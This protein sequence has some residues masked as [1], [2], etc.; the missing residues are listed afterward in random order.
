MG[1]SSL[2]PI[3][4]LF[5]FSFLSIITVSFSSGSLTGSGGTA[6]SIFSSNFFFFFSNCSFSFF[7]N[8]SFA[9]KISSNCFLSTSLVLGFLFFAI[10][11]FV[12]FIS[13][14]SFFSFLTLTSFFS[15]TSSFS[16][17][18]T[19]GSLTSSFSFF[20]LLLLITPLDI[21]ASSTSSLFSFWWVFLISSSRDF[22]VWSFSFF[23][24]SIVLI[25]SSGLTPSS[26]ERDKIFS[27]SIKS[28]P[29]IFSIKLL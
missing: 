7:S 17:T 23:F 16:T 6:F 28:N 19:S 10:T 1:L 13:F 8:F 12:S 25:I 9:F 24:L 22:S 29:Q 18:F 14:F 2:N 4:S 5:F 26:F 11:V 20:F 21:L 27:I 15:T 3:S